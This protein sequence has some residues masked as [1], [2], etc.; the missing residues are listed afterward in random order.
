MKEES[1]MIVIAEDEGIVANPHA[2][3]ENL[4]KKENINVN[5]IEYDDERE[6]A[7]LSLSI[8]GREYQV[9]LGAADIDIPPFIR[10]GHYFTEEELKRIDEKSVGLSVSMSYNNDPRVCFYDQLRII[11]ALVPDMIAV[12]DCPSEKILSGNWVRLA[13]SSSVLPAPRYLFTVQAISGEN[14][15]V[16]LHTHGLKR[17][18][19]HELEILGSDREMYNTHYNV[20]E[21]MAYRMIEAD[22]PYSVEDPIFLGRVGQGFMVTT[23]INWEDALKYYDGI[24]LGTTEDRDEYH[25]QDTCPV[26]C[27]L[28]PDDM[29]NKVFTKVQYFDKLLRENPIFY[30]SGTETK[31]MRDL[32]LER[33]D[34]LKKGFS[35]KENKAS[36]KI[37]LVV[38]KEYWDDENSGSNK[39]HIWFDVVDFKDDKIVARLVQEPYY[40]SGIK[41]GDT[42]SFDLKDITDWMVLTRDKRI[43][44]D[45]AYLL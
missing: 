8:D 20:L 7:K 30:I 23:A 34:Y 5:D 3:M 17:C 39:E 13:A 19:M 1:Y 4:G 21:N 27:Y 16:W 37:G 38:D 28:N 36:V 11:D 10:R 2:L 44:P 42:K 33:V 14:D 24:E 22:E 31:R 41:K 35:N 26:M 18:G 25:S 40:V 45:D 32:A 9:W 43:T 29:D 6:A 15:E 12:L